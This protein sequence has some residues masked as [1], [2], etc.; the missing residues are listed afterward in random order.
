MLGHALAQTVGLITKAL[1]VG[2][3]ILGDITKCQHVVYE[4]VQALAQTGDRTID[5]EPDGFV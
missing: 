2:F 3:E 5:L 1:Y 4:L